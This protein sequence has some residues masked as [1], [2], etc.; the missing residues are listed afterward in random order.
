V[1]RSP[2]LKKPLFLSNLPL[3]IYAFALEFSVS[4]VIYLPPLPKGIG[5]RSSF[6]PHYLLLKN[7][8]GFPGSQWWLS[9]L[10]E[11]TPTHGSASR[12]LLRLAN[13]EPSQGYRP[14]IRYLPL[15]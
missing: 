9:F 12:M 14:A 3:Q 5:I 8:A 15:V 1:I 7:P 13:A 11:R 6:V 4:G 10:V 2:A